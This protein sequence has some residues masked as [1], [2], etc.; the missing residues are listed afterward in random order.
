MKV[1]IL[2]YFILNLAATYLV[3]TGFNSNIVRFET[4][5]IDEVISL[6]GNSSVLLFILSIGFLLFKKEK[7]LFIYIIVST[8]MLNVF[9]LLV[10]YF[11]R[12]YKVFPSLLN[13]TLFRNPNAGFHGQIIL[14]GLFEVLVSFQ[15]LCFMPFLVLLI[16]SITKKNDIMSKNYIKVI[17][18][19]LYIYLIPY[20][21]SINQI[22]TSTSYSRA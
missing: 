20:T 10:G 19:Y 15:F 21:T 1:V 4:K 5:L 14:D 2:L 9:L 16:V 13:I 3:T 17:H 7:N 6:L 12:S 22:S 8:L 11:T 18:F